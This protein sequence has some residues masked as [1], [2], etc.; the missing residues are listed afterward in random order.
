MKP[1][2]ET[3]ER[4]RSSDNENDMETV[5]ILNFTKGNRRI[6]C[7][8]Q[9]TPAFADT[10]TLKDRWYICILAEF[11]ALFEGTLDDAKIAA[12]GYLPRVIN[13]AKILIATYEEFSKG[14]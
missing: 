4:P 3:Y 13:E 9:I 11:C 7:N 5:H 12:L 6:F 1:T 8:V 2:W 14:T 10:D